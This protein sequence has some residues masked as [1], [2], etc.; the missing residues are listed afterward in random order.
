MN[1]WW[2]YMTLFLSFS[3]HKEELENHH[4]NGHTILALGHGGMGVAHHYPI[5]SLESIQA[6]LHHGLDGSEIDIQM[7]R[8]SVLVLYHGRDLSDQTDMKGVI[9]TMLWSEVKNATYTAIPYAHY[10]IISLDQ[11]FSGIQNLSDYTFT[12]DCKLYTSSDDVE[13]Y[14]MTFIHAISDILQKYHMEDRVYLESQSREFLRL[15]KIKMP[16][17]KLFI[18]PSAFEEGLETA[19]AM[20]LY[21]IT[22]STR[23][24]TR[25]QITKAH[26]HLL[27]VAIWNVHTPSEQ[28]RA[29]RKNPDII[30]T[31]H[32]KSLRKMLR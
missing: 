28:A 12:F 18:Y 30:Q 1:K 25:E 17:S 11:L 24:I 3:C 8:D 13:T 14:Y 10:S 32:V 27:K 26:D 6:C 4:L 19:M 31:D 22:I 7:T 2:V 29:I 15:L 20:G 23:N 5:N 16:D 21:G 9:H